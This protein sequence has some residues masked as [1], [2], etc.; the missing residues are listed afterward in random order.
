MGLT[1]AGVEGLD[2]QAEKLGISRSHLVDKI[3]RGEISLT[4]VD[5]QMLGESSIG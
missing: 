2:R 4:F 5:K 3:G 1:Q